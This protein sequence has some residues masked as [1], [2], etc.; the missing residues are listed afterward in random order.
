MSMDEYSRQQYYRRLR[1]SLAES[2][3]I[4]Y[5]LED[6]KIPESDRTALWPFMSRTHELSVLD[7]RAVNSVFW[8]AQVYFSL[9]DMLIT[10]KNLG[11]LRDEAG[12]SAWLISHLRRG[13]HGHEREML[14]KEISVVVQEQ[15]Q[16]RKPGLL[17][18][19]RGEQNV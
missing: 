9:T 8:F 10:D 16:S 2:V 14:S 18:R 19:L 3:V 1:E 17:S 5:I 13:L 7:E 15:R 12:I 11:Y 6:E 4:P